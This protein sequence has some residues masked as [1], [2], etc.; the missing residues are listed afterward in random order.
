M[1]EE[2]SQVDQ[3]ASESDGAP[4]PAGD[5]ACPPRPRIDQRSLTRAL[6]LGAIVGLI[7]CS[8]SGGPYG[9]EGVIGESGAG[10]GVLLIVLTPFIVGL[11]TALVVAELGTAM[12]VEGGYYHWVKTGLGPFA[13]FLEGWWSWVVAWVDLAVYP[14]LFVAYAAYFFPDQLGDGASPFTRWILALVIIWV[15]G[16]VNLR[17]TKLV[18]DSS[19]AFTYILIAPFL[20]LTAVGIVKLFAEGGS[21]PLEP[22][23]N[24]GQGVGPAFGAGLWIVMWNYSGF[25]GIST[26]AEEIDNPQRNIPRSLAISIPLMTVVYLIPVLVVLALLGTSDIT[27]EEGAFTDMADAIGGAWLGWIVAA[28]ALISAVALFSSWLLSYSRLPFALADDGY[29]PR[30]LTRIH[31]TWHTPWASIVLSCAICSV[32]A[33]SGFESL[34]VVDVVLTD[35]ALLLEFLALVALRRR[36]PG[37][38][39][40]YR[41]PGGWPVLV[42]VV[43]VPNLVFA[44]G[45]YYLVV[46]EGWVH[47]IGWSAIAM[48]TGVVAYPIAKRAKARNGRDRTWS[49]TDDVMVCSD[50]RHV[51]PDGVSG[52]LAEDF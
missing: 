20:L 26:V 19:K 33:W 30:S 37:V 23:T 48:L 51:G 15:F 44:V 22:F 34:I 25:D 13:G 24:S 12:P 8:V 27:W 18:G 10:M 5:Q 36:H 40:P 46:E 43:V 35:A 41:I 3:P 11:P 32:F 9:L 38:N 47:G 1:A 45:L 42:T 29:L 16:L 52:R 21:N 31:P 39:R 28:V 4:K 50:G 17:G 2:R 7:Y 49:V 6:G 14:V